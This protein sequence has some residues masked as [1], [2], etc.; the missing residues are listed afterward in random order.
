MI[1]AILELPLWQ[2]MRTMGMISFL[3]ITAGVCLGIIYSMPVWSGAVKKK[4]YKIHSTLTIGGAAIGMLHGMISVIDTYTPF[5]WSEVLIPFT[6][7]Y[8]PV[9]SGLGTLSGYLL[10]IVILTTDLRGKLGRKLWMTLH[11]LAYPAFI[12]SLVHGFF[13]GTDSSNPYIQWIYAVALSAVLLTTL[14]RATIRSLAAGKNE[15]PRA[16]VRKEGRAG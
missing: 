2:A 16:A 8:H 5:T 9:L 7:D 1:A 15:P 10:L 4:L 14:V 12:M 3:A 13:L 11:L 6:A